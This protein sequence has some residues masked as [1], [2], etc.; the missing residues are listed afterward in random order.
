MRKNTYLILEHGFYP[1]Y[2][3]H[4]KRHIFLQIPHFETTPCRPF[5]RLSINLCKLNS[6][7]FTLQKCAQTFQ[8]LNIRIHQPNGKLKEVLTK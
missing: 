5:V 6:K 7:V 1:T 2:P 4:I 3:C 8:S